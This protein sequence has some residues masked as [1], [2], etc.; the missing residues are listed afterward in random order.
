MI[1]IGWPFWSSSDDPSRTY[2]FHMSEYG[3]LRSIFCKR[4]RQIGSMTMTA[5]PLL[6]LE[7]INGADT[8][9]E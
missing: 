9:R 1:R 3:N 6:G 8:R 5:G 7:P 4:A 2:I